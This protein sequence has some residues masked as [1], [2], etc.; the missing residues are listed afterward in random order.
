MPGLR[1]TQRVFEEVRCL[2]DLLSYVCIPGKTAR[3]GKIKL[4]DW[5]PVTSGQRPGNRRKQWRL[6][7]Q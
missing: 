7:T 6:V 2:S 1:P 3:S 5:I 4:V